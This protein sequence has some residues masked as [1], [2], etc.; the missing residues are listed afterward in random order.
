MRYKKFQDIELSALGFGCMR[1]PKNS[2]A[3]AD[4]N[5]ELAAEM[6]RYAYDHGVNYF[7]TAWGY[8]DHN[9][10]PVVG[11]LLKA[12]PRD[13]FYLATKFPGYDLANFTKLPEIFE[14]QL[15]RLDVD[16]FDF[17]LC[18]NVTEKNIDAYLDPQ[19]GVMDYLR[20]QKKAGRIRHLG[21][22]CH[23]QQ[24]VLE[25][26]VEAYKDDVEFCQIQLN[27]LDWTLQK[28]DRK[29]EYLKSCGIP[30]WVMEPVRGGKLVDIG[31]EYEKQLKAFR[32][33]ESN[34][35]WALRFVNG[36]PGVTM[37]LS[38]M[39]NMDQLKENIKTF[40]EDKPLSEE[41]RAALL[42]I[43]DEMMKKNTLPCT[44]CRYC[45]EENECPMGLDIPRIMAIYNE[46][47]Y[48]NGGTSAPRY[49]GSL[50]DDKK[51]SACIG[52]GG[53]A[54]V[55]PQGLDIPGMMQDFTVKYAGFYDK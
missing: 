10:E 32:P 23:G 43:T 44:A 27:Y 7:D 42:S 38:G 49:I 54:S 36:I 2:D 48:N 12:F 16:Y 30:V 41:E 14:E 1:L 11:K 4:I 33:D 55:C 5:E 17:Y 18:H 26:F 9:S 19:Y 46:M 20:E 31:E 28:A 8:H 35:A 34:P 52:C 22:S 13:S 29:V 45:V 53:C 24:D 21:F 50:P 40:S 6:F 39:S 37:I 15:K 25:R 47:M 3:A 51:P